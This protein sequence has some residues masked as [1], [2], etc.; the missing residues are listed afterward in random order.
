[1]AIA[2]DFRVD[3]A[4]SPEFPQKECM[5][6]GPGNRSSKSQI[7]NDFLSYPIKAFIR[8]NRYDFGAPLKRSSPCLSGSLSMV[9]LVQQLVGCAEGHF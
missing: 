2:S 5:G 1:M 8:K 9:S 6:F 7:A 3:G 4:K